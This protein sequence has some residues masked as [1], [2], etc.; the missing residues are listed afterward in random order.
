VLPD[1][2]TGLGML[3]AAG[4]F[5]A[6][7]LSER[8]PWW[9]AAVCALL[10]LHWLGDSLDGTLARV[11]DIQ[12]PR[13]GFHLDHLVDGFSTVMIGLGL[14]LSPYLSFSAAAVFVIAYLVLSINVYLESMSF[15]RFDIGYG[16][17]GPTEVRIGL[18]ALNIFLACGVLPK[19]ITVAG[20]GL[21]PLDAVAV[22]IS[23]AMAFMLVARSRRNLRALADAEPSA[24]RH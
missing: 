21:S 14:G 12:R 16:K 15:G 8:S 19:T 23:A 4:I 13:Y 22:V 7:A 2:L 24:P 11:R 3:A 6:Y 18:V 1:D 10:L 17:F 9:L 5:T 20:V